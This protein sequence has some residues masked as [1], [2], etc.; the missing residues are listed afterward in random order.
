MHEAYIK[1]ISHIYL[2]SLCPYFFFIYYL[3]FIRPYIHTWTTIISKPEC[4][5]KYLRKSINTKNLIN[6]FTIIDVTNCWCMLVDK[7]WYQCSNKI[8]KKLAN[9]IIVK[10]IV[11]FVRMLW[12]LF[13]LV[14]KIVLKLITYPWTW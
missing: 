3:L 9:L 6:F 2:F 10:N 1:N 14:E 11:K 12:I 13:P 7:T 8:H 4:T 5:I